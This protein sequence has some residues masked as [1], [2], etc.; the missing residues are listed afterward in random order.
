MNIF[1]K[2]RKGFLMITPS[3]MILVKLVGAYGQVFGMV[4]IMLV[5]GYRGLWYTL[6]FL[7]FT[8]IFLVAQVLGLHQQQKQMNKYVWR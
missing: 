6:P 5:L 4:L 1:R 8:L 2:I 3:Q 7:F